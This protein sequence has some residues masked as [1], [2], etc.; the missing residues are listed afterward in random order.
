MTDQKSTSKA[1]PSLA[2]TF[3]FFFADTGIIEEHKDHKEF[4][5][6]EVKS[7]AVTQ[8]KQFGDATEHF[9]KQ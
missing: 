4:Q 1:V 6:T 5:S 8:R 9:E 2:D 7:T 3:D